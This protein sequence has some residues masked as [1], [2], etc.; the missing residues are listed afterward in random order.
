MPKNLNY[1][2]RIVSEHIEAYGYICPGYRRLQHYANK[3]NPLSVDHIKPK[4]K[5][6]S[7][8]RNNLRVLC[9]QCNS[10]RRAR[11]YEPPLTGKSTPHP[12]NKGD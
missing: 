8:N 11:D 10:R 6:G 7:D 2:R 1:Y 5:G 4:S 3:S 12:F 9:K